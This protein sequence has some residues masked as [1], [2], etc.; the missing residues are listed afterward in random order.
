MMLQV[1]GFCRNKGFTRHI[2]F[3]F[4]LGH[5]QVLGQHIIHTEQSESGG[6]PVLLG[7]QVARGRLGNTLLAS[8]A[9]HCL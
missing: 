6:G 8:P 9:G 2:K 7:R 3:N 1:T 5:I 4:D